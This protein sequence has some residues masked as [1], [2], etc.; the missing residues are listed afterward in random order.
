MTA[1]TRISSAFLLD[2]TNVHLQNNMKRL[3]D[4]QETISSG[5]NIN[6]PS[7]DPVG[8]TRILDLSNTLKRDEQF[9]HN[10]KDALS[11]LQV[12]DTVLNNV[13]TLI[14]RAM[15][16]ATQGATFTTGTAG[17]QSIGEEI[18]LMMDQV[19]QLSNTSLG[20]KFL[21]SGIKTNVAPFARTG[22]DIAF[23]GTTPGEAY[24]RPVEVAEGITINVNQLGT[25]IFGTVTTNP[26]PP[27]TVNSG[28]G[29]FRTLMTLKLNLEQDNPDAVR[30]RLDDLQTDLDTIL[31][32]QAEVGALTNRLEL[33]QRRLDERQAVLTQQFADIQDVDMAK[34]IS[35]LNF[36]ENVFQASLGVS[37]R[38][39][40]QSLL[41]YI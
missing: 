24:Q 16:L 20:G 36:Q 10:I 31:A 19:L 39:M 13:S 5:K 27:E 35:D 7:D 1:L 26:A 41:N 12:S 11:E 8:L 17:R 37:G 22:N 40:Q 38:V 25:D 3:S 29:L 28:A 6:R 34:A 23:N 9:S 15:E 30:S 4:I 18:D 14:H 32:R 21:Y 33:T 2:R